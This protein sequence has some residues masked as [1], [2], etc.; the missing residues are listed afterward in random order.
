[1]ATTLRQA[2]NHYEV[3]GL[4]PT[5][6]E[7]EIA[8]AFGRAMS[9]FGARP[10]SM[11]AHISQAF[12]VLRNPEKRRSY[13]RSIGL[14]PEPAA[15]PWQLAATH[16]LRPS[17][18]AFPPSDAGSRAVQRGGEE[19]PLSAAAADAQAAEAK[20]ASLVAS[21]RALAEPAATTEPK[22]EPLVEAQP[23]LPPEPAVHDPLEPV[24]EHIMAVGRAEKAMLAESDHAPINWQRPAMAA[25]G[26]VLAAGLFGTIAGLTSLAEQPKY[27][28][29][30]VTMP[31]P[32]ASPPKKADAVND[33][34]AMPGTAAVTPS[35]TVTYAAPIIPPKRLQTKEPAPLIRLAPPPVEAATTEEPATATPEP[36]ADP[37]A[38]QPEPTS[39]MAARMPLPNSVIAHTLGRIGYSCGQVLSTAA[40][41]GSAPGI[42]TVSCASG[43]SYRATPVRGRYHFRRL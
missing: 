41:E 32:E 39:A 12:A 9:M 35:T 30:S 5:A 16:H 1:M 21:L 14:M 23:E 38:P 40:V 4:E 36:S 10:I 26:L 28:G 34:E 33:S 29:P 27:S 18:V 42:F 17:A 20:L 31:L 11:A 3:L 13:D 15:R 2:P 6:S 24:I 37:L 25:G 22:P 7:Q 19:E 8:A 43:A